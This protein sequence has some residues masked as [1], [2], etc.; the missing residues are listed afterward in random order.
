[1]RR[2]YSEQEKQ[3]IV[4]K[5]KQSGKSAAQFGRDNEIS[6]VNLLRWIKAEK[7]KTDSAVKATDANFVELKIENMLAKS[8][9]QVLT[10]S[11]VLA[12]NGCVLQIADDFKKSTLKN[13]LDVVKEL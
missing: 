2:N 5:L 6:A 9:D 1:M 12:C 3:E 7:N 8:K 4:R 10:P 11:I 13:I